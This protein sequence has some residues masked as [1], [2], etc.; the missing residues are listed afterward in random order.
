MPKKVVDEEG[1]GAKS[2]L[3]SPLPKHRKKKG[4]GLAMLIPSSKYSNYTYIWNTNNT[5]RDFIWA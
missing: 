2:S 4:I 1:P 5:L 3:L